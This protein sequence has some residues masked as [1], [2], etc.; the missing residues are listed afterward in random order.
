MSDHQ[1]YARLRSEQ[2]KQYR[3]DHPELGDGTGTFV[4]ELKEP[5]D[6]SGFPFLFINF[7]DAPNGMENVSLYMIP[8]YPPG[9]DYDQRFDIANELKRALEQKVCRFTAFPD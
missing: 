7:Y 8:E 5:A 1:Y 9:A 3:K 2:R 6:R 4:A